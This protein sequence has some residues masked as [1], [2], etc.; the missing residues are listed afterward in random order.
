MQIGNPEP[1]GTQTRVE[2]VRHPKIPRFVSNDPAFWFLRLESA[3]S[4][5]K[6][7]SERSKANYVMPVLL[8]ARDIIS[9]RPV[10]ADIFT[11][12]KN[13]ILS[14]YSVSAEARLRQ[15]LKGDIASDGKPSLLLT[16]L[17]SLD[18]GSCSK[19][20]LKLIFLDQLPQVTRGILAA[21]KVE[22][23]QELADLA[24]KVHETTSNF[25]SCSAVSNA[26]NSQPSPGPSSFSQF[27]TTVTGL[28]SQINAFNSRLSL[29]QNSFQG[30]SRS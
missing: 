27:E 28:V 6:V 7:T 17:R 19:D 9:M 10:P 25:A 29:G 11:Q 30:R 3:F 22:N 2:V 20:V 1:A 23:L 21:S 24:N 26:S 15:F 4:N 14:A 8:C 12:L 5:Y 13:R 18:D 16:R